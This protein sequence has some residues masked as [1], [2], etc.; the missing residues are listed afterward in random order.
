MD[1][2]A[3]EHKPYI[4]FDLWEKGG[5]TEHMGGVFASQRLI[6]MCR[7]TPGQTVLDIGC[8]TGYTACLLAKRYE[9][10]VVALDIISS[11]IEAA[12]QRAS[13]VGVSDRVSLLQGDA[14]N[15]QFPD[16]T[17][18]HVI[19]ESLLVFCDVGR[20]CSEVYRVLKPGGRFGD[21]ELTL[22]APPPDELVDLL[23]TI[24]IRPL[25]ER[26]W[27]QV[28]ASAGFAPVASLV[29]RISFREQF[30]SHLQVDGLFGYMA[31][32]VRGLSNSAIRRTFCNRAMPR[33][34]RQ[35]LPYV[36]YGLYVG[37]KSES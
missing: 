12:R 36:G 10:R 27:W 18:D 21:N 4:P 5:I 1:E 8:G 20:V 6:E 25:Q 13:K 3:T 15:L 19:S 29:R 2:H 23:H 26:E 28:Y 11:V 22:L 7:V 17:F 30:H 14:H 37:R 34:A 31:A 33:A 16:D 24:G 9:A 32:A 35:F